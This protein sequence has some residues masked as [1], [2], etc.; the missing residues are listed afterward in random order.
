MPIYEFFCDPCNTIFNFLS[1]QINTT[2]VPACPKCGKDLKRQMSTFAT[3]GKAREE[4]G[5]L[6]SGFDEAKMELAL[7]DL[8]HEA[9]G[10][11]EE[12][13][14]QMAQFMRKLTK[15]S[16]IDLGDEMEEALTRME[17]GED[18]D[19]IEEAMGDLLNSDDPMS[20]LKKK[21]GKG[22]RRAEPVRDETLYELAI[23]KE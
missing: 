12:D 21:G 5:D 7:G 6:P 4:N 13:P 10:L 15:K 1:R 2:K 19:K 20:L 11:N 22:G 8:M 23:K 3:I 16:G 18:P 17:S 9:E 14:K